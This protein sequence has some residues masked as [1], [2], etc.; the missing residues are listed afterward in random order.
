MLKPGKVFVLLKLF[1]LEG[2]A[3][4][5]RQSLRILPSVIAPLLESLGEPNPLRDDFIPGICFRQ[6]E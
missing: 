1:R 4:Q 6:T 3:R 5:T 2:R